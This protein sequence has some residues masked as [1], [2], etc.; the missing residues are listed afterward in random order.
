M[1][2]YKLYKIVEK[3]SINTL[4]SSSWL[5]DVKP[6]RGDLE[7]TSQKINNL[8]ERVRSTEILA[9]D[10]FATNAFKIKY[11]YNMQLPGGTDV[12]IPEDVDLI[13]KEQLLFISNGKGRIRFL[14]EKHLGNNINILPKNFKPKKLF[15]IWT[16]LKKLCSENGYVIK[17]HRMILNKAYLEGDLIKEMNIS[18]NNVEDLGYFKTL[19][20]SCEQIKVFTFKIRWNITD[21]DG[22]KLKDL[23][24]R[25]DSSGGMLL[26]GNHP[27]ISVDNLLELLYKSFN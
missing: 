20:Q 18:T 3:T 13:K 4:F 9:N 12:W 17:L 27:K 10:I 15:K 24:I 14:M 2:S 7:V 11:Q 25:L 6:I 21:T 19:I 26:Y 5:D 1:T 16:N 22:N 23:T 8:R